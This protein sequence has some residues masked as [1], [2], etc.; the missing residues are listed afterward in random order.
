MACAAGPFLGLAVALLTTPLARRPLTRRRILAA[1][2][3]GGALCVTPLMLVLWAG[4]YGFPLVPPVVW[5]VGA[6][7]GMLVGAAAVGIRSWAH[8]RRA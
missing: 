2:S 1:C 6:L 7:Y 3:A 4:W 8:R 5:I